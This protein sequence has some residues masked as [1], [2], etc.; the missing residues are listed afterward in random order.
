M[1][2]AVNHVL[3]GNRTETAVDRWQISF[4][5]APHQ[6]FLAN[7]IS[8]ELGD[9][10]HF[11]IMLRSKQLELRHAGHRP[12]FVHHLANYTRRVE[13]CDT[14]D[15]DAGFSLSGTHKHAAV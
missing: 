14:G 4:N 1:Y 2:V 3:V 9:A 12:V 10:D 6:H 5:H 15:V 7:A 11:K 13:T 8:N